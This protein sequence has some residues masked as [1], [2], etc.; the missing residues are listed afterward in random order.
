MYIHVNR[1]EGTADR[2]DNSLSMMTGVSER[3]THIS[4]LVFHWHFLWELLKILNWTELNEHSD[5][6]RLRYRTSSRLL[7]RNRRR[8]WFCRVRLE[9]N[10]WIWWICSHDTNTQRYESAKHV[11]LHWILETY[12]DTSN[13]LQLQL[14]ETWRAGRENASLKMSPNRIMF[15]T[16]DQIYTWVE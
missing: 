8:Q 7:S 2:T 11:D 1:T 6:T 15:Q 12:H 3:L 13:N 14:D 5:R 9:Q 16:P 4:R 10:C